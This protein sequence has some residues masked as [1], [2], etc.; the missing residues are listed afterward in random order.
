MFTRYNDELKIILE[1]KKILNSDIKISATCVRVPTIR[2]HA[3]SIHIEFQNETKLNDIRNI[4]NNQSGVIIEDDIEN[5]EFPEPIKVENKFEAMVGRIRHD[6][7]DDSK[8]K[9]LIYFCEVT[10][11]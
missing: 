11:F 4:L 2:A 3:E 9:Q 5:N 8:K 1:T 10:S 7:S 6:L